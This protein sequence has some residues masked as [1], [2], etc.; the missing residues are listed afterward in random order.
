MTA[1]SIAELKVENAAMRTY[2]NLAPLTSIGINPS[3]KFDAPA[4]KPMLMIRPRI[5][6]KTM[7]V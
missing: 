7:R 1:Y 5:Y 4:K 3:A 2:V 6:W